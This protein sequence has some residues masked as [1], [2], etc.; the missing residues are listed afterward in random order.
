MSPT[1]WSIHA[2][3]AKPLNP[4]V[5]RR[6]RRVLFIGVLP[7]LSSKSD[8]RAAFGILFSIVSLAVFGELEPHQ[9]R[10]NRVLA[11]VAQYT[12]FVT[13]GCGSLPVGFSITE[14]FNF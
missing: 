6:Y 13:F 3:V 9:L 4:L 7:L 11:R 14:S 5:S 12:V 1:C 10:T 2:E 8:R